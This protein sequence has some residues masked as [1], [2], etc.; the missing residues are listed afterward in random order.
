[1]GARERTRGWFGRRAWSGRYGSGGR[2]QGYLQSQGLELADVV[3][4][5]LVPVGP[6]G[7][8]VRAEVG[9]ARGRV[10]E[11]VPD[12]GQDGPGDGDLGFG[13]AAAAGDAAV[14]FAEEGPGAGGAEGGLAEG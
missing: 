3:A 14:P 8:I 11:Q 7:D 5:L 12:D 10:G 2:G 13:L 1:M 6:G 9:V 4:D